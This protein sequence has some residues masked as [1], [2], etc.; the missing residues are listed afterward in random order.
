MVGAFCLAAY[1]AQSPSS[2]STLEYLSTSL[3]R[4]FSSFVPGPV[5]HSPRRFGLHGM[6][7]LLRFWVLAVVV[8]VAASSRSR[9]PQL[10]VRT[11]DD[12]GSGSLRDALLHVRAGERVTFA[13]QIGTIHLR[14]GL[15]L[16]TSGVTLDAVGSNVTVDTRGYYPLTLLGVAN[17]TVRGLRFRGGCIPN[18]SA[19]S[20]SRL[21]SRPCTPHVADAEPLAR[22]PKH[23]NGNLRVSGA[24][25]NV[26]IEYCSSTGT[27]DVGLDITHDYTQPEKT[28]KDIT[29][30]YCILGQNVKTSLTEG[31]GPHI[32]FHHNVWSSADMR[33]PQLD[34]VTLFDMSNNIVVGWWEYGSRI[35]AGSSGNLRSNMFCR[36]RSATKDPSLAVVLEASQV[37]ATGNL[38]PLKADGSRVA[39]D[40]LGTSSVPLWDSPPK[41]L[42]NAAILLEKLHEVVGPRPLDALD[43]ALLGVASDD[44]SAPA[45]NA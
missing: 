23:P 11:N 40:K 36:S 15:E 28:P 5:H 31:A 29:V 4:H 39:I 35:R 7:R 30:R 18:S 34:N 19:P 2:Y 44:C 25:S 6:P 12:A 27:D 9:A 26:T 8:G 3:F 24:C 37:F 21:G 43:A 32:S 22:S 16:K 17:V 42:D 13:P 1:L 38:G 20:T 10:H 33:S 45:F 14:S 41:Q